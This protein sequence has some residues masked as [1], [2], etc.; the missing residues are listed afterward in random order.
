MFKGDEQ[1]VGVRNEWSL[2]VVRV[3]FWG[4][5]MGGV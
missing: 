2:A 3:S 4:S 1:F 5:R